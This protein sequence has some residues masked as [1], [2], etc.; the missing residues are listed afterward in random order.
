MKPQDSTI[1]IPDYFDLSIPLIDRF[2]TLCSTEQFENHKSK[3]LNAAI[4]CFVLKYLAEYLEI[5]PKL[6][7]TDLKREIKKII[8]ERSR[9]E[10][11]MII[12]ANLKGD[13]EGQSDICGIQCLSDIRSTAALVKEIAFTPEAQGLEG[14]SF[15]SA[16]L[17]SGTGILSAAAALHGIRNDAKE[18]ICTGIESQKNAVENSKQI[19]HSLDVGDLYIIQCDLRI[20]DMYAEIFSFPIFVNYWISET[21]TIDTPEM[22]VTTEGLALPNMNLDK[23][24]HQIINSCTDPIMHVLLGMLSVPGF[25]ESIR[26]GDA[27]LFPNII[28]GH[29]KPHH[30][31]EGT[32][33]L[34]TSKDSQI[35]IHQ[36]GQDFSQF[37]DIGTQ[38]RWPS[39]DERKKTEQKIKDLTEE[40][41][42][43]I[44]EFL[45]LLRE[46]M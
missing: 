10:I 18:I 5:S 38:R 30:E 37:E 12:E 20:V 46:Q 26:N 44:I 8:D 23:A 33:R 43:A 14:R 9:L 3:G 2:R 34:L 24:N 6:Q 1:T 28:C 32:I 16:D 15:T 41:P 31:R 25:L 13:P 40:D 42:Q 19:L 35:P 17:G 4:L 22:E 29:Y 11:P 27:Q 36:V 7:I 21:F 39:P 45:E